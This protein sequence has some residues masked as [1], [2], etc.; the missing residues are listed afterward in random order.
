MGASTPI[1]KRTADPLASAYTAPRVTSVPLKVHGL[2]RVVGITGRGSFDALATAVTGAMRVPPGALACASRSADAVQA[3]ATLAADA[4][5]RVICWHASTCGAARS[6][7]GLSVS[8]QSACRAFT[9][10]GPLRY[11]RGV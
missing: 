7:S 8:V 6:R 4:T 3:A 1:G 11:L 10:D 9:P 2:G 5:S